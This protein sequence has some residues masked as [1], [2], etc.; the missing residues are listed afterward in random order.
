MSKTSLIL[1]SLPKMSRST[2]LSRVKYKNLAD[3][4]H[5]TNST[6]A[7]EYLT[8]SSMK[9]F[10]MWTAASPLGLYFA[11][12]KL[13]RRFSGTFIHRFRQLSQL[14][15]FFLAINAELDYCKNSSSEI[16]AIPFKK[17]QHNM[18][19]YR[20]DH[21]VPHPK[22]LYECL[23]PIRRCRV[24]WEWTTPILSMPLP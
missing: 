10:I 14:R 1:I 12:V 5:L 21:H 7:H 17:L 20:V 3:V 16:G 4:K 23:N 13:E 19:F 24:I 15:R 2:R 8:M 11:V 18:E 22:Y 9:A 6:S